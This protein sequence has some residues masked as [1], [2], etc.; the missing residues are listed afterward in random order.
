VK[1]RRSPVMK[2][3]DDRTVWSIVCFFVDRGVRGQ[4][5]SRRML[6]A[7][8]DYARSCGARL[9]EAYPVDKDERSDS[10]AMFF[11]A[12]SMFHRA[13]FREV[14]RRKP[15]RPVVGKA[16]RPASAAKRS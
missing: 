9:V 10:D 14:A 15:T 13:G 5:L 2:P 4:G 11:G 1:L 7:A 3:V 8:I 6:E 12:K 16:I